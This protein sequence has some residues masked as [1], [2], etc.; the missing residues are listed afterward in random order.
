MGALGSND[1]DLVVA[2]L[3]HDVL[4]N[5][6][7]FQDDPERLLTQF[8]PSV[9]E[10]VQGMTN[11]HIPDDLRSEYTDALQS[12]DYSPEQMA[13]VMKHFDYFRGV[14]IKLQ[15]PR[16]LVV[17]SADLVDNVALRGLD[18]QPRV[19][20]RIASKYLPTLDLFIAGFRDSAAEV[21]DLGV[22]QEGV[23]RLTAELESERANLTSYAKQWQ[24]YEA[25]QHAFTLLDQ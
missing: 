2:G 18:A 1:P 9:F 12:R 15:D 13:A 21:A 11:Q 7:S 10:I 25:Q 19:Q 6:S 14:R 3:L 4:E 24:H 23:E 5:V 16:V 22:T 8:G 20:R 17:K